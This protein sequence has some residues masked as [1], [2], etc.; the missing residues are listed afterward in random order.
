[1]I[2]RAT[3]CAVPFRSSVFQWNVGDKVKA[4]RTVE[5]IKHFNLFSI[6][7][8]SK[9]IHANEFAVMQ[10]WQSNRMCNSIQFISRSSE[11][12]S[13]IDYYFWHVQFTL[14]TGFPSAN[15]PPQ[16]AGAHTERT[17]FH[18]IFLKLI[19]FIELGISYIMLFCPS[20]YFFYS[21]SLCRS[22]LFRSLCVCLCNVHFSFCLRKWHTIEGCAKR[23][24]IKQYFNLQVLIKTVKINLIFSPSDSP[25]PFILS[26]KMWASSCVCGAFLCGKAQHFK[27]I[28]V[29]TIA[30]LI[31]CSFSIFC[32]ICWTFTAL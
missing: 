27:C 22:R 3:E 6:F 2:V 25:F 18:W 15:Q 9:A 10:Q 26:I 11:G 14:A 23:E 13:N 24:N 17:H 8:C 30:G 16:K 5:I 7:G 12:V 21:I 4:G 31:V 1:M 20:S 29:H 19:S 32:G 28:T